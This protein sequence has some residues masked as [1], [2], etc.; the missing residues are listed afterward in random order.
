MGCCQSRTRGDPPKKRE[1]SPRI[2]AKADLSAGSERAL[3]GV[4]AAFLQA[5]ETQLRQQFGDEFD[6]LTTSEICTRYVMPLT[7]AR[8]CAWVDLLLEDPAQRPHLAPATV[9]V[10][11]A[12]K[13]S[14]ATTLA[15]VLYH[16]RTEVPGAYYWLDLVPNN[17]HAAVDLPYEWW[18]NTFQEN[19]KEIGRVLLVMSPWRD[20]VPMTR[21]WCLF[22]MMHALNG[23]VQLDIRL[24]EAEVD[25]F[26][27]ALA[28][29]SD[30]V[31]D[32]LVRV[33]AEKAEAFKASDRAM[34]FQTVEATLGFTELN[35]RIKAELRGWCLEQALVA[36][37]AREVE[38]GE[39]A[40][41]ASFCMQIGKVLREFGE[42][43]QALEYYG[44]ALKIRLA[45]LGE[46]HPDTATTYNNMA[47]CLQQPGPNQGQ[48]E[49]ALEYYGKALKIQLAT[50][51]EAHPDTA[52]TYD[53][54]AS[55]YDSQGQYEQALEY[56]GKALKIQL[57]ALGEAHPATATTYNNM[58]GVYY[59]QG[60]YEQAL[61]Y[62]GKALKIQLAT[63]GEEHPDTATTYNNMASVYENQGQYEQALEYYGKALKIRLATLG[64]AHPDTA[65]TFNNMA[66][67]YYKQG[68]YEQAL[69][70]Y[71]K[72]LKIHLATLGEAHP[73]TATTYNNMAIVYKTRASA[74]LTGTTFNNMAFVYYKQGQHE[75]ALEYYGKALTIQLATVG[76]AHPHTGITY[77]N[78][79]IVYKTQ[80]QYEQALEYYGKA[81]KIK[82]ATLGEA[83]PS[84]RRVQSEICELTGA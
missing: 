41:F 69:E 77:N 34:I 31:M 32:M 18:C 47:L 45:T 12:W 84:T 43:E 71:G 56:Y 40:G 44:K 10:S 2:D 73:H 67:V 19:I 49:Q 80:G 23:Q 64:E 15:T 65:T 33:Q 16:E 29:D 17:Q 54:M 5:L 57:A 51:G 68:Q 50:L 81:L 21:A 53:N 22:E 55:V 7:K 8:A 1:P 36:A 37:R 82:L 52:T 6:K 28:E 74:P 20:P 46:A 76:E 13:Y 66:F 11:H 59:N 63:L 75:Q 61:E 62:Y 4:S 60:Q 79:A 25:G 9:F 14:F 72:A 26:V 30:A 48:Y 3:L 83:H 58:A 70:Y 39:G 38:D 78:M 35:A 42:Y 27:D 24:P